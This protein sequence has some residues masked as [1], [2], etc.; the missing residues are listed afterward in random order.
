V[1]FPLYSRHNWQ[2]WAWE[3]L[4]LT[5]QQYGQRV[6]CKIGTKREMGMGLKTHAV[7]SWM[8]K[9]AS[10]RYFMKSDKFCW[11]NIN[12]MDNALLS[13]VNWIGIGL[14]LKGPALA[15]GFMT[16]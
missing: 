7:P 6:A 13:T 12:Y 10:V 4:A 9:I 1:D 5:A 11:I 3:A 15:I 8:G 2:A 16:S 14:A